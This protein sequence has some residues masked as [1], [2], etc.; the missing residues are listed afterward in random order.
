MCE[1]CSWGVLLNIIMSSRWA[2]VKLKSFRIP[3]INSWKNT[4]ACA[5]P[6]GTFMHSNLL[7]GELNAVFGMEALSQRYVV[8][9]CP[10]VQC[11]EVCGS[12]QFRKNVLYFWHGPCELSGYLVENSVIYY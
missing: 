11:C 7:K 2:I 9:T 3:V 1:R 8:V 12:I 6:S 5:K 4:S 10:K